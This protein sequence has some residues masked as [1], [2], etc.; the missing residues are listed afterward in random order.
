MVSGTLLGEQLGP[1]AFRCQQSNI[2]RS[3]QGGCSFGRGTVT[4]D[5]LNR[6]FQFDRFFYFDCA[7]FVLV[8]ST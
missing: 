4:C 3:T 6:F 2:V 8:P 5:Q 7:L 1:P